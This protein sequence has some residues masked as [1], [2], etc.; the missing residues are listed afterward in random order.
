MKKLLFLVIVAVL[1]VAAFAQTDKKATAILDEVSV[2][3]KAY[4]TIKVEFTYAMDNA[5]QK[6]HDKF[7]GTLLS[8]GDKYKLTAAGQDVI[9]DGKTVWTYLKDTKEVQINNVGEDDDAF[10]PTKLLSG[11]NKD[12]KSKFIEE[13][14]NEQFIELYPLKK[15]KSFTKV[16]LT[17]DKNKKQI[18]KFVIYDR[19]GSTFTYL[20]DKFVTDQPIADNVFTFN[21]AEHPGVEINDMR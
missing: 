2:K 16:Q 1:N 17:I 4:K 7:K 18:S 10:T 19:N 9:S 8:K 20:V 11:Y 21:K 15:G 5:K 3:T 6:I 14:G 13:K 12:F